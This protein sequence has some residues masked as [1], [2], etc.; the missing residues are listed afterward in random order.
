MYPVGECHQQVQEAVHTRSQD[1]DEGP[2]RLRWGRQEEET[3]GQ[4]RADHDEEIG[5]EA[6][7]DAGL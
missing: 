2:R 3:P 7:W 1:G 6:L 4:V 5:C